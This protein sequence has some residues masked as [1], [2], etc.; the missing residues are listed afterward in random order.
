MPR[1]GQASGIAGTLAVRSMGTRM[2]TTSRHPDWHLRAEEYRTIADCMG[3]PRARQVL[4][5]LAESCD[6]LGQ[7][8]RTAG[9]RCS[10]DYLVR[11]NKCRA[12]AK[13][14]SSAKARQALEQVA[15]QWIALA[16]KAV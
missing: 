7:A 10:T 12:F 1:P 15:E 14:L 16:S 6:R 9:S 5:R 11:A 4:L 8:N 3:D 13:T 2:Q